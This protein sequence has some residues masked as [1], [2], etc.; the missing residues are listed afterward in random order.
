LK[1]ASGQPIVTPELDMTLGLYYLTMQTKGAK[2]EGKAYSNH[3]QAISAY[4][5]GE[6]DIQALIKL[7]IKNGEIVNTTIGR[8]IANEVL[9]DNFE[10]QNEE[11]NKK[12]IQKII[13]RAYLE[14]GKEI[15]ARVVD[16]LKDLGFK[17]AEKSGI[18]F[19]A[20][21]ISVPESKEK[22]IKEA[23]KKLEIINKQYSKGLLT[24]EERYAKTVELWMDI[25]SVI[26]KEMI[27]NFDKT[28]DI[29]TIFSSGARG[30]ISQLNQIAGMKGLV[31]DPTGNI[32]EL[33]IISNFKD[34][35]SVF[36]YFESTHGS[37][38]GR[39]DT[40]L[41]TSQAGYL[42]RRLVDVS[43]DIVITEEHCQGEGSRLIEK[44][45]YIDQEKDWSLHMVGRVLA[46]AISGIEKGKLLTKE[47]VEIINNS[48][49]EQVEIYSLLTCNS[50]K[51]VCQ[52]CY[53]SDP[54]TGKL[55]E[56]GSTVG[57]V[58]AQAIGEPGT[59]LTM[60]TF[61][62]GGAAGE[63]ITSGLPRVEEIFEARNPKSLA[64]L[65]EIDGTVTIQKEKS[66][67][68]IQLAGIANKDESF[69]MPKGYEW[70]VENNEKVKKKQIIAE[71]KDGKPL[72]TNISGEIKITKE[73]AV[74]SGRGKT[75]KN[76][77]ISKAVPLK[78][79]DG[80]EIK[81]G[82]ALTDGHYNLNESLK[83]CGVTKTY[84]YIIDE[85]QKIYNSQGQDINDKHLEVI[86]K[87][88]ASKVKIVT[89][90]DLINFLPGKLDNYSEVINENIKREKKG[91][92][93][94][95]Y[96]RIMLGMSRVALRTDSFLSAASFMETTSVL[97]N[98][99]ISGK[100]DHLK[101]LKEN[102][103][104]GKLIPA[105]TGLNKK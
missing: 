44:K 66:M 21:D 47:D 15:T 16:D 12:K 83:L 39:A 101:G 51:G 96:E 82:D 41:R 93:K 86:I 9:P 55:V 28:S 38:K 4:N 27:E 29:Y 8:A 73:K 37:R 23:N 100:T 62:T 103:I 102:I 90:D 79:S 2:G 24:D 1:P 43:Q 10:F 45:N 81:K 31:A 76:Y 49:A 58:A 34:G 78:V 85:V 19:A 65:A 26:E 53:G 14:C 59:Q 67:I 3:N 46:K 33:P 48:D 105:G 40:A 99:A 7:R 32:I 94:I 5:R 69:I 54:A 52:R 63:D 72:R 97:I 88:M 91:K 104:I 87:Q 56:I 77:T 74:I 61:H 42:T 64:I 36:E 80:Q 57:I 95:E 68:V 30:N 25:S 11:F 20:S 35:L 18:T 71:S 17:Y 22:I 75:I 6:T 60:R 70:I 98:A 84:Q 50:P 92:K 89:S 13:S